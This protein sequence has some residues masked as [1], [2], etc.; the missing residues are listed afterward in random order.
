[1]NLPKLTPYR[2]L[3]GAIGLVILI[4]LISVTV[5]WL[6]SRHYDQKRKEYEQNDKVKAEQSAKLKSHAEFLEA[7]VAELEPKLAAY[8]KLADDKK[9]LDESITTKIDDV[10]KEGLKE[11]A[12]TNVVIDCGSR[13]DRTCAKF[14][15][16]KPPIDLDCDAYKRKICSR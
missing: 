7:R 9:R 4:S 14:H 10:V 16:L 15:S 3:A 8:E 5:I 11:D 6:Q 2:I 12:S 13:A 1:M